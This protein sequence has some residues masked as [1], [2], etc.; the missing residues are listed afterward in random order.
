MIKELILKNRSY[1]R[2]KGNYTIDDKELYDIIELAG[3]SAS[4]G[5]KQ[6]LKYKIVNDKKQNDIIFDNI[7]WAFYLTD[8]DGPEINQ[9]PSSYILVLHD[10]KIDQ[11]PELI[12]CDMGLAIQNMLLGLIEKGLGGCIIGSFNRENIKKSININDNY[13]ILLIVAAGKPDEKINLEIVGEDGNIKY[14]R[15]K[16]DNHHVPK[17][18]LE[19]III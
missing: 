2:F 12:Y 14:Y 9:R 6:P 19:D 17:R 15:D 10:K 13:E 3:L 5:N 8:W 1:R 4:A 7:K 16:N 11:K 18:K